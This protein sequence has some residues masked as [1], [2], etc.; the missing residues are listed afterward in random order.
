MSCK[1]IMR[2]ILIKGMHRKWLNIIVLVLIFFRQ[3]RH[4]P[5]DHITF[6]F[7]IWMQ[8][9]KPLRLLI[10]KH[11]LTNEAKLF[12]W[13]PVGVRCRNRPGESVV[14][15]LAYA[16][17]ARIGAFKIILT[18]FTKLNQLTAIL[19]PEPVGALISTT[20]WC[21]DVSSANFIFATIRPISSGTIS[22]NSVFELNLDSLVQPLSTF[23]HWEKGL[24]EIQ[25]ITHI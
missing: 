12:A 8:L 25:W 2:L 10:H 19:L 4:W 17:K 7:K 16:A 24:N 20:S 21:K 6:P 13:T 9:K 23:N 3:S 15:I 18:S 1:A 11:G 14:V 5:N 22:L